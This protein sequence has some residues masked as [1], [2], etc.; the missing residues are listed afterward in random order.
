MSK[1]TLVL[2]HG[3][4]LNS[5]IWAPLIEML[6]VEFDCLGIDLP[7]Y[8]A[9]T[10]RVSPSKLDKLGSQLLDAAPDNAHWCAWSLGGMAALAAA[11]IQPERFQSI[12]LL[13]TT[14]RFVQSPCWPIGMDIEVFQTFADQLKADYKTAIQQFLLLQA[15]AG[16]QAR[17]LAKQ[18]AELLEQWPAPS[19]DTLQAGLG[20]LGDAD[21]RQ[22]LSD[23]HVPCQVISGRRDRVVHPDAGAALSELLPNARYQLLNSGHAPHLSCP[24]D[25]AAL[26]SAYIHSLHEPERLNKTSTSP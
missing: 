22:Q 19:A 12:N 20:I 2:V 5:A 23:L 10:H 25:L 14:P 11:K 6:S 17:T 1:P 8:G 9:E 24:A 3:W 13:C 7:G 4:G 21:L 26:I 18:A 15:G 16:P